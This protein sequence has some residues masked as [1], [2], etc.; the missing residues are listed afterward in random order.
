[1][2]D[3]SGL[4]LFVSICGAIS[5]ISIIT[6]LYINNAAKNII[7]DSEK[8]KKFGIIFVCNQL[9]LIGLLII[10]I[11]QI[12]F[13]SYYNSII[14]RIILADSMGMGCLI[15][16]FL[17]FKFF[18]W[19]NSNRKFLLLSYAVG[20]TAWCGGIM[21]SILFFQSV[22]FTMPI[23]RN[24]FSDASYPILEEGTLQKFLNNG[25]TI[26]NVIIFI[27]FWLSSVILLNH[28][29]YR[30]GVVKFWF[31]ITLPLIS[32]LSIFIVSDRLVQSATD[33]RLDLMYV[34]V[35][36]YGLPNLITGILLF[37]PFWIISRNIQNFVVRSFMVLA[38]F[39]FLISTLSLTVTIYN[40]PYPPVG[41]PSITIIGLSIYMIFVG[42]YYSVIS[43]TADTM[44][45]QNIRKS[46]LEE[47]KLLGELSLANA[48]NELTD[49]VINI[50]KRFKKEIQEKTG[51][52]TSMSDYE[53]KQY[54]DEIMNEMYLVKD[55]RK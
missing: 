10:L 2:H 6:L 24:A 32:F 1:M 30:I 14:V 44:L 35:I 48:S 21:I 18:S 19:Y 39:G 7:Q 53:M 12:I 54:L 36:G 8:L 46:F 49:R 22:L 11:L 3:I 27:I 23:D 37:I 15:M 50:S 45:R 17:G 51:V 41:L 55:K 28:H 42:I 4:F 26:S 40:E 43:V 29:A 52:E 13:Y 5:G 20:S 34:Y 33:L 9:I 31:V 47:S 25:Y 38:A 16:G